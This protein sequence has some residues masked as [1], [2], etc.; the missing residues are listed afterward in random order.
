MC[1]GA[2]RGGQRSLLKEGATELE[3]LSEA[4]EELTSSRESTRPKEK[5]GYRY[6]H[7]SWIDQA[8]QSSTLGL[9]S[10]PLKR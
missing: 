4:G 5:E 2:G 9:G 10:V 6:L 1:G 3:L 8:C 7:V